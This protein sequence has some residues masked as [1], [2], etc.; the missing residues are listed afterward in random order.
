M[1]LNF[2][3]ILPNCKFCVR[4]KTGLK[5]TYRRIGDK[6]I[7]FVDR[8]DD[9]DGLLLSLAAAAVAQSGR[10]CVNSSSRS[11]W[12]STASAEE[13]RKGPLS[14]HRTH[15][16]APYKDDLLWGTLR[17]LKGPGRARTKPRD[18]VVDLL[19]PKRAVLLLVRV[20]LLANRNHP[21][22]SKWQ[23]ASAY[24]ACGA[25]FK[26]SSVPQP[27]LLFECCCGMARSPLNFR[28]SYADV[29]WRSSIAAGA[30]AHT[31]A[32]TF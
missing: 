27:F 9:D 32:H 14:N 21:A 17:T 19:D 22:L 13:R 4:H 12:S 8:C 18:V 3:K 5:S 6:Y 7:R 28:K 26:I 30:R 20:R 2:S 10:K 11:G 23:G 29:W 31:C 15:T 25:A 24:R 1:G 16:K